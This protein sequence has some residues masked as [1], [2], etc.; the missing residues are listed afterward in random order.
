MA[1]KYKF[2]TEDKTVWKQPDRMNA[3]ISEPVPGTFK[4]EVTT[5]IVATG[6]GDHIALSGG[7]RYVQRRDCFGERLRWYTK[8]SDLTSVRDI[9]A[10]C[11][12]IEVVGFDPGDVLHRAHR[13]QSIAPP[14]IVTKDLYQTIYEACG[15]PY[16]IRWQY[17]PVEEA[18][19]RVKQV[20]YPKGKF[21]VVHDDPRRK[22][23]IDPRFLPADVR[24]FRLDA[25]RGLSI[26][27]YADALAHAAEIHCVDSSV[28]H[29]CEQ[30]PLPS[31]IRFVYYPRAKNYV[32]I[33]NDY[34]TRHKWRIVG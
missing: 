4:I 8:N 22:I 18:V 28:R 30:L 6:L 3:D 11:P 17:S 10:P 12:E 26:L 13:L 1:R 27:A 20:G 24:Q 25:R 5:D 15:V 31:S 9:F 32:P 14:G 34:I 2:I 7:A 21:V 33:L 29:L 23:V 16:S 19:K